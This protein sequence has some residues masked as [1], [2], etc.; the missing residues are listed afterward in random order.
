M[1]PH[2]K[3]LAAH[4]DGDVVT[5]VVGQRPVHAQQE[6]LGLPEAAEVLGVQPHDHGDVVHPACRDEGLEEL[7][8]A[9]LPTF[10][11]DL[12][13]EERREVKGCEL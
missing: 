7:V 3:G 9:A 2:P 5:L 11:R 8:Q 12:W 1:S 13:N 4:H 6:V 10:L